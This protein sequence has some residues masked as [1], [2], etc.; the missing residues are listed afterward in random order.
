MELYFDEMETPIG[1]MTLLGKDDKL[2]RMD[3]GSMN[4]LPQNH[5]NWMTRYLPGT[6]LIHNPNATVFLQVKSDLKNY[7]DKKKSTFSVD[8]EFHGTPFQKK[9]WQSLYDM[10]PFGETKSYKDIALAIGN[11]KYVRAVG[12]AVGKNP[13]SIIV[14]CHRVIGTNGKMVGYNG[15]LDRKEFLLQLEKGL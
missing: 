8:L 13:F 11:D 5:Q 1:S 4:E 10:I 3:Y 12:T 9:V 2:I 14:P 15:G 7:F 6:E